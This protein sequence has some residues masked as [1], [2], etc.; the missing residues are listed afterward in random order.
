MP[1]KDYRSDLLIRLKNPEYAALYLKTALEETLQDGDREA[2]LLA[3]RNV[4]EAQAATPS[5]AD[6]TEIAGK[7]LPDQPTVDKT[8]TVETLLSV[9]DIVGLRL[10]FKS[11]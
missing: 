6:Q 10:E 4:A 11:A 8:P 9:L 2:F 7:C 3:L 1:V 5:D